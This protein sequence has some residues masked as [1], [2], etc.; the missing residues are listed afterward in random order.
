MRVLN[1]NK[2]YAGLNFYLFTLKNEKQNGRHFKMIYRKILIYIKP[3]LIYFTFKSYYFIVIRSSD[4]VGIYNIFGSH[5][6]FQ[7]GYHFKMKNKMAAISK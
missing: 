3:I 6:G 4:D 7:D 5:L 2:L 1:L